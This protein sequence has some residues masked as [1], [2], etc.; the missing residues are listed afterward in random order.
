MAILLDSILL[1][2]VNGTIWLAGKIKDQ[3]EHEMLDE[4]SVRRELREIYQE[5]ERELITEEEFEAREEVLLERLESIEEYK[6][7]HG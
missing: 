3:A 2:P 7:Q 1:A 6:E 5:L 4:E